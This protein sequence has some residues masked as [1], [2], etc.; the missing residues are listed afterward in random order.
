M[1]LAQQLFPICLLAVYDIETDSEIGTLKV[2][3]EALEALL[4]LYGDAE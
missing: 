1:G 4:D 3:V 2:T